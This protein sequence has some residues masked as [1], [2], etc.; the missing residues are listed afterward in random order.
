MYWW[1][2]ETVWQPELLNRRLSTVET[3]VTKI[4]DLVRCLGGVVISIRKSLPWINSDIVR[5]LRKR[6]YY[7]RISK[8]SSS[9]SAP[10]KFR[11]FRN[12]AV[13]LIRKAKST[14]LK[15]MH[16]CHHPNPEG[17]L[18]YLQYS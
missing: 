4:N 14:L 7:F 10:R 3:S 15:A 6:D 5:I 1:Y 17:V 18:V 11:L 2:K 16:V 9:T 8:F 13:S 12:S